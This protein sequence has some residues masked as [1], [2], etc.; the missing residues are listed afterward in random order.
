LAESLRLLGKI[1]FSQRNEFARAFGNYAEALRIYENLTRENPDSL[2]LQTAYLEVRLE[3]AQGIADNSQWAEAI[4]PLRQAVGE[5]EE[6]RQKNPNDTEVSR[7]L[8]K[9]LAYLGNDLSWNNQQAEADAAMARGIT[10]AESLV[11]AHPTDANLRQRLWGHYYAACNI[12]VYVDFPRSLELAEKALKL[13]EETIALD[14]ANVQARFNLVRTLSLL[15][16]SSDNLGKS[17]EALAYLE[18][19]ARVLTELLEKDPH[20]TTYNRTLATNYQNIGE[21]KYKRRDLPGALGEF[22]KAAAIY[23]KLYAADQANFEALRDIAG[24]RKS[25]GLV[26]DDS[27]RAAGADKRNALWQTAKDNYQQALDI[28]VQL[29]SKNALAEFDRKFLAEMQAAVRK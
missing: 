7:V 22:E 17:S 19:S 6:L 10:I 15:G 8:A 5:L 23:E 29:Q 26:Y 16:T 24:I 18:R 9:G 13:V 3:Q 28:L 1:R 14:R 21:A 11:A 27:A 2:K 25:I 4:P 20:N 12:Y